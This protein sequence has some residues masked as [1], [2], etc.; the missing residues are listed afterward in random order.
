MSKPWSELHDRFVHAYFEAVGAGIGPRDLG[1][2]EAAVI[3]RAAL[4]KK[5]GAWA[6]L[7]R[8]EV[9]LEKYRRCTNR[10]ATFEEAM[11]AGS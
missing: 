9:E 2:S 7:D 6:A 11:E 4:L 1:R 10:P 3:A 5:S 8:A